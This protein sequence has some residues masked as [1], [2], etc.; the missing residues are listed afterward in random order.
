M[1]KTKKLYKEPTALVVELQLQGSNMTTVPQS[2]TPGGGSNV[3]EY[4][5]EGSSSSSGDNS[6]STSSSTQGVWDNEW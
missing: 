5:G 4:R 2:A 6:S 3:R 1:Q